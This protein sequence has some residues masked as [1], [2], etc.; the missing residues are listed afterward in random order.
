LGIAGWWDTV[1]SGGMK[2]L[3]MLGLCMGTLMADGPKDW[4]R[5]LDKKQIEKDGKT[6]NYRFGTV[7]E[8]EKLPLL[9]FLHGAGERGGDNAAQLKHG[10]KDLVAWCKKEEQGCHILV[11]QCPRNG[12]WSNTEGNF[13]DPKGI[14]MKADPAWTLSLVFQV[15][16]GLLAKGGVDGDRIYITGLSMGGYGTFDA[17]SRRPEF[18][19]AAMPV[20]GGGDPKQASSIKNL[21]MWVFHGGRD[22]VVPPEMSRVMVEAVKEAG[23]K[24][25]YREYPEAGHD[26]W[27]ATYSDP[28]VWAWLFAQKR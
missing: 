4:S 24:P 27:S 2:V 13:K 19:A 6:L 16:D 15:V 9:V 20:C 26:S 1:D 17:V 10:V 21:P 12:W 22:N 3:L 14:T 28:D 5:M 11:P 25:K 7:G 8:G 18:F 23:G